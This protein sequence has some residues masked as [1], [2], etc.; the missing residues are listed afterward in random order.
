MG[1]DK[2]EWPPVEDDVLAVTFPSGAHW[3]E[4]V[5]TPGLALCTAAG[6]PLSP[7]KA[8]KLINRSMGDGGERG[9][10]GQESGN[11]PTAVGEG[12]LTPKV[13]VASTVFPRGASPSGSHSD[14]S[15]CELSSNFNAT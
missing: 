1:A 5:E 8:P 2:L 11:A 3:D 12:H 15:S 4:E 6:I 10:V 9:M 14:P 7:R 13:A